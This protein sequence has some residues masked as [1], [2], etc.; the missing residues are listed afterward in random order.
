[1]H[2]TKNQ[3]ANLAIVEESDTDE[4][5]S[6]MNEDNETT[7]LPVE[8]EEPTVEEPTVE[9]PTVEEPTVEEPTVEEENPFLDD[10]VVIYLDNSNNSPTTNPPGYSVWVGGHVRG[11]VGS[12][13]VKVDKMDTKVPL[14]ITP[15]VLVNGELLTWYYNYGWYSGS[16]LDGPFQNG[17]TIKIP[18]VNM[19]KLDKF[20]SALNFLDN[21]DTLPENCLGSNLHQKLYVDKCLD[22]L[23]LLKYEL[24]VN[25]WNAKIRP[26]LTKNGLVE[27]F[28]SAFSLVDTVHKLP[29]KPLNLKRCDKVALRRSNNQF[30]Y[31]YVSLSVERQLLLDNLKF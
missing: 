7:P 10:N 9:E 12:G 4:E 17:C 20:K 28:N 31:H 22:S 3:F 14:T 5:T 19:S 8:D 15:S 26:W 16:N 30:L 25:D 11:D 24:P 1:M 13:A 18:N 29:N 21:L 27:D 6:Q 2:T 23:A